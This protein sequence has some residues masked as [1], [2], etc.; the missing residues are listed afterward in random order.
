MITSRRKITVFISK[1]N[2]ANGEPYFWVEIDGRRTI[3]KDKPIDELNKLRD[4]LIA[5][6]Q[7][8]NLKTV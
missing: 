1:I 6:Y 4:K 8:E 7:N 2:H 5:M 3:H